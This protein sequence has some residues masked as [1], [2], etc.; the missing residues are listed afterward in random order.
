[1]IVKREDLIRGVLFES[2]YIRDFIVSSPN[3]GYLEYKSKLG[4]VERS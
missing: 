4:W 1:M 2:A 3:I